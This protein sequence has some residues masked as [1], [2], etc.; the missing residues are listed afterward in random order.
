MCPTD[1][2]SYAVYQPATLS[3]LYISPT[4]EWFNPATRYMEKFFFP[5]S[6]IST[7]WFASLSK[8]RDEL[9]QLQ[10]NNSTN[11]RWIEWIQQVDEF[12]HKYQDINV[13]GDIRE[14]YNT[15]RVITLHLNLHMFPNLWDGEQHDLITIID[16]PNFENSHINY[17][18]EW[19]E[20][21][22]YLFDCF[23]IQAIPYKMRQKCKDIQIN[24]LNQRPFKFTDDHLMRDIINDLFI[25]VQHSASKTKKLEWITRVQAY[26]A[27]YGNDVVP[28]M[29]KNMFNH[30]RVQELN[31]QPFPF[32]DTD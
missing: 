24:A 10:F 4:Q 12:R 19:V 26:A 21:T 3:Y 31:M 29:I 5:N 1:P 13:P 7:E 15:Y 17:K 27:K 30:I 6:S 8:L 32:H 23:G 16:D 2:T 9:H 14:T 11:E 28:L 18:T 20:R 25:S 22:L